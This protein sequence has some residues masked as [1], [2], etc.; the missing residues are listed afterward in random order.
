MVVINT[1]TAQEDISIKVGAKSKV[2]PCMVSCRQLLYFFIQHLALVYDN[3]LIPILFEVENIV[4][5][6]LHD[7]RAL[8]LLFLELVNRGAQAVFNLVLVIQEK[9]FLLKADGNLAPCDTFRIMPTVKSLH[10]LN[11]V[12]L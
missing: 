4:L 10:F 3:R 7:S 1:A 8:K 6:L 9:E 11:L 12:F 2:L 5:D